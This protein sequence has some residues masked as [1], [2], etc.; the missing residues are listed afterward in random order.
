MRI[1]YHA[2]HEQYPPSEL[3]RLV[4]MAE[5]AGFDSVQCSDHFRPWS[6]RQGHSGH[7]WSWL[8]AALQATSLPFGVVAAPGYRQHPLIVAQAAATLAEMFPGRFWLAV[9]SGERFNEIAAGVDWPRKAERNARLLEAANIM[10]ALWAGQTVTRE[11]FF[12][13]EE[14][15]LYSLPERPPLLA[16]AA[17]TPETAEWLGG[18][19]DALITVWK[20][21]DQLQQVVDAFR[22]GGGAGKP[23]FLK[24]Q[25]SYAQ[26]EE[27]ALQGAWEQWRTNV[28][29]SGVLAELRL[30]EQFEA[31]AQFVRPED[32]HDYVRISADPERHV[33]W[34]REY[35]EMGF[36]EVIVHN[37]NREQERY[38]RDF[39][40]RVLPALRRTHG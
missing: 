15:R 19:A 36:A 20:P 11:G 14:A 37:V 26:S 22:L 4:R 39:G 12:A 27:E 18:W 24:A 23:M 29:E 31:A 34:L 2:A 17:I 13:V 28:F 5:E 7:A 30:P 35:V 8:G 33:E 3:L 1:G 21:K 6:E 32:M 16:G 38:I 25:V 10:R 9:G 40:A